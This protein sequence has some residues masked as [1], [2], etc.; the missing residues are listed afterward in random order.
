MAP[1]TAETREQAYPAV[2]PDGK[3]I[4]FVSG[5]S[6]SDL[7]EIPLDGSPARTLLATS[8]NENEPAWAPNGQQFAYQSDA[9]GET[10]IWL[11]G[12]SEKVPRLLIAVDAEGRPP[13][14]AVRSPAFSP[15]GQ[16]LAYELLAPSHAILV[17]PM[18]GGSP[19]SIDNDSAD[20]HFPSW[21]PDGNWIAYE[22]AIGESWELAKVPSGGGGKPVVLAPCPLGFVRWSPA[23]QWILCG[24]MSE[25]HLVSPEGGINRLF[26]KSPV[27]DVGFSSDGAT[28]YLIRRN[29]DRK[30]EL[31]F[32]GVPGGEER[33][34]IPLPLPPSVIVD[35]YSGFSLHPD[36]KRFAIT[37]ST[38]K[39]DIWTME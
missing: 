34:S 31:A 23:G 16:R 5:G 7:V 26:H 19:V 1:I 36:G 25:L 20:R 11:R 14:A 28:I 10:E 3:K 21:S 2:S 32:L 29:R 22:R 9:R 35:R 38:Q 33:K 30:W 18:A 4:A 12:A 24:S 13:G 8:R 15:D 37:V 39:T 6:D 17:V 27:S